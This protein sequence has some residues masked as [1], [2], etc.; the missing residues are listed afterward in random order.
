MI[1]YRKILVAEKKAVGGRW[2]LPFSDWEIKEIYTNAGEFLGRFLAQR[3][4]EM[5]RF[6]SKGE[7]PH[8]NYLGKGVVN[9]FTEGNRNE[10]IRKPLVWRI[11]EIGDM[12]TPFPEVSGYMPDSM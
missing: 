11:E 10:E 3:V 12:D 7:T 6:T 9:E 1:E 4:T 5:E 2:V 8:L